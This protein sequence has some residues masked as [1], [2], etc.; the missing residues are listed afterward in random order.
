M[1]GWQIGALWI[2]AGM[3]VIAVADNFIGLVADRMGLWQFHLMRSGIT[4]PVVAALA[5]VAGQAAGLRPASLRA[6]L[7]RSA[8]CMVS[9]L[10]YYGALPAVGIAQVAAGLFTSPI[11]VVLITALQGRERVGWLHGAAA[12]V[13]FAGVCLALDIGTRPLQPMSLVG[14]GAG[15]TWAVSVIWTRRH[16]Q[17]ETA[18]CLAVFQ[19]L[20]MLLAAMLGLALMPLFAPWLAG[21]PGVEFVTKP[22]QAQD[23]VT[24]GLILVLGLAGILSTGCMA[25]GYKSGASSLMGMFDFSFMLWGP[26]VAWLLWGS[27]ITWG[28]GLGMGLIVLAGALAVWAGTRATSGQTDFNFKTN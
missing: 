6:V 10:L 21:V 9:M 2:I 1:Q 7:G 4:L 23:L 26:L 22:W 3:A 17:G 18:L 12:L 20:G 13:G 19:S 25:Q 24:F 16:C 15:A 8:I 28:A 11:W 14:L 27:T 5:W